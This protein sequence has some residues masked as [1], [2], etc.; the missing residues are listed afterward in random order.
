M[1]VWDLWYGFD[2]GVR[3]SEPE[4]LNY[5]QL[6]IPKFSQVGVVTIYQEYQNKDKE[7]ERGRE[8]ICSVKHDTLFILYEIKS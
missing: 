5:F 3:T 1:S 8:R 4:K 6:Q 7:R 2:C